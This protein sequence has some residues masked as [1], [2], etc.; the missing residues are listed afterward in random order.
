M[1][2][3]YGNFMFCHNSAHS[4]D[5]KSHDC[6]I[7]KNLGV[8][9]EKR[10]EADNCKAVSCVAKEASMHAPATTSLSNPPPMSDNMAGSDSLPGG[11]SASTEV[12]TYDSGN[13]YDYEGKWSDAMYLGTASTKR[14][15]SDA[16]L[17]LHSY[18]CHIFTDSGPL[19]KTSASP[20]T[21]IPHQDHYF[22]RT[23]RDL[24]GVNTIFLPKKV[25]ALLFNPP[26][27]RIPKFMAHK[28][29]KTTLVVA[30]TGATNHMLPHK[31]AFVSYTPSWVG[32]YEWETTLL[33]PLWGTVLLLSF[34]QQENTRV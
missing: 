34:E 5:Q 15:N 17:G 6:L 26:A 20:A 22:S 11:F 32:G 30:D 13:E 7:L 29:K 18:C 23:S 28:G 8:K 1:A 31:L 27:K 16:Y 25:L 19:E 3:N 33:P 9:I 14:N 12:G 24:Q 21:T 10:T 2:K 4:T